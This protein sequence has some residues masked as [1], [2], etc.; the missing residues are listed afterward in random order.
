M[1]R[2]RAL[3]TLLAEAQRMLAQGPHPDR[4]RRDA[5]FLLQHVCQRSDSER[6]R[7]WLLTHLDTQVAAAVAEEF[8]RLIQRR[9]AGEPIQY[10][11]G[12]A[13]FY[14]L[15]FSVTPDVLI[16]RPETEHLV[17]KA[18][19]VAAP[20]Q[21]PRILDV[22]TGSGAVAVAMAAHLPGA[23][24]AATDISP[25]ALAVA[26]RNAERN[27]L[28][29]R[30]RFLAGDLLAPVAGEYFEI[31][32]SNPPYVPEMDRVSLAVE[33]REYEPGSALFAGA[34]GLEV[35]RRLIPAAFFAL[36]PG[37]YILLEIGHGQQDGIS[38]LLE[39]SHF[40]TKEFVPDL[41]GIPRVAVAQRP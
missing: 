17:E 4:C 13:E 26:R 21:R 25:A 22:G 33:V 14:G 3:R 10:I 38:G 2:D 23:F 20:F 8:R 9:L 32:V 5:E 1:Q 40:H 12:E 30:I 19:Q 18:L 28:E 37:G 15:P 6:S 27:G 41:Q 31:I 29:G 36:V 39:A 24:I 34:D 7:A 16:P 35:Y 11:V